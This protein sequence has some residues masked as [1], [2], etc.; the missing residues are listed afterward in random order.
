M[1][2]LHLP[3]DFICEEDAIR[4]DVF[5]SQ[6]LGLSRSRCAQLIDQAQ[7][8]VNGAV[9]S[10][11]FRLSKGDVVTAAIPLDEEIEAKP[12][13]IPLDVVYE[14]KDIIVVNKPQGM[15]VHPAPGNYTGT[16]VNALLFHCK[17][18]LSGI[19]GKLRPG[20]VHR[21]D[22]DTS[23]LLIA[24]KNDKAHQALALMF[25]EHSFTRQYEAV[26]YGAPKEDTGTVSLAIGRSQKDRKKMAAFPLGS[27]NAKDAVTH[28]QVLERFPGYSHVRLTLETGRT[29]Q[30]RVHML[31][32]S[33]PVLADPL[34][35]PGRKTFQLSG[36]CLHAKTIGFQHPI[37]G[38]DMY[39]DS[40]LPPYFL[41]VLTQLKTL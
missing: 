14:D 31:A 3:E 38:K 35:A 26:L 2:N 32:I 29:H 20:I 10:K 9:R 8:V 7:V 22:K 4:L 18:S 16:L 41:N 17:N 34:Y 5:L 40:P 13:D 30:I 24:A 37:T 27:P 28:F 25:Q 36:Q 33:C 15:V 12:E 19:N 11:N 39:F 23:G 1:N 6:S 21:I